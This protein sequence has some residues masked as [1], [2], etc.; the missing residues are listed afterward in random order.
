M[1]KTK[2]LIGLSVES[3][4]ETALQSARVLFD[5]RMQKAQDKQ[6]KT[7]MYK[8]LRKQIARVHTI[9]RQRQGEQA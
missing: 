3:L 2:E 4:R 1:R 5:L 8:A 9:L 6:V 7:H